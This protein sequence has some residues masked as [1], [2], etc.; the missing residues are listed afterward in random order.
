M[1]IMDTQITTEKTMTGEQ[2]DFLSHGELKEC[3]DDFIAATSDARALS[4][5]CRDYYDGKQWTEEQIKELRRRKMA[6][7]VN[8]RIKVKQNGLL[9]LMSMRKGDPKAFPRNVNDQDSGAAEAATDALRFVA[10]K[11]KLNSTF[12]DAADNFFC[13]GYTAVQIIAQPTPRGDYDVV[14]EKIEWDRCFF[15]VYSTKHDFSDSRGKGYMMWMDERD[16][17]EQFPN[18]SP[19]VFNITLPTDETFE[20]KPKWVAAHGKKKR[21]LVAVHYYKRNNVWYLS[22]YTGG[23]FLLEPAESPYLDEYDQPMCPIEMEHAYI[24]RTGDRYG[25]LASFLDLQDEINHRRSKALFLLSQRQTFG[26]RGAITDIRKAKREL[27][28]PDGH[29]EVGQGEYGKDFGIL[30]T[31]DMAQGQL[32]L[33]QEAKAE[34]DAQSVNAQLSGERQGDLSGVAIGKLQHSGVVELNKLFDNF[35]AFKERVYAQIWFRVRQFWDQE[36]WVRIT[37]DED[38]LRFVGFNVPTTLKDFLQDIMDD[39]SKPRA[40]RL[41]AS[42]RMIELENQSP[43]SL[44]QVVMTKNR[45]AEIDVDIVISESFDFINSSEEQLDAILKYGAQNEFDI[46]DLLDIS[47]ITGKDRLI[48]KIEERRKAAADAASNAPPD[49]QAQYLTAKSEEAMASVEVKKQE[50]TQTALE[51]QLLQQ[52]T[53]LQFKGTVSA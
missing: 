5:R 24:T 44:E 13:E 43:Q 40:M 18:A 16:I 28:K 20:D 11:N 38:K 42:A 23:G 53:A 1:E 17:L 31:G 4:E 37:D 36:K 49:P 27:A 12:L 6:P 47:N 3:V 22:M 46:I 2:S 45:P 21:Y 14:V 39:D 30:P 32:E 33:L 25:E 41:G 35:G 52:Q 50:A 19:E 15:D 29:L 7:I 48:K 10:D 8:N 9:G 34:M 26:S 51:N